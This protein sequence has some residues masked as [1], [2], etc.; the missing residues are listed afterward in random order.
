MTPKNDRFKP[1]KKFNGFQRVSKVRF[2]NSKSFFQ[3]VKTIDKL[4]NGFWGS[5]KPHIL[6][7][8]SYLRPFIGVGIFVAF[9]WILSSYSKSPF[10]YGF[11]TVDANSRCGLTKE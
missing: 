10:K 8:S 9:L 3:F 11:Q 6:N 2:L 7:L 5:L 1:L 4:K